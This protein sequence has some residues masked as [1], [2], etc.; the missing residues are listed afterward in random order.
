MSGRG[1]RGLSRGYRSAAAVSVRRS[2]AH[3]SASGNMGYFPRGS[4]G[5]T[6]SVDST[7]GTQGNVVA[8]QPSLAL[9]TIED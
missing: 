1:L 5:I 7:R 2:R 3:H 4:A 9:E 6:G 8:T